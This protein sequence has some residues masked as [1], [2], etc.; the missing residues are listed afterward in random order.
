MCIYL[1]NFCGKMHHF[2]LHRVPSADNISLQKEISSDSCSFQEF[3]LPRVT[4]SRLNFGLENA[5]DL[6]SSYFEVT[7]F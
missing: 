3:I 7:F 4:S 6:I 1:T 2:A 5:S